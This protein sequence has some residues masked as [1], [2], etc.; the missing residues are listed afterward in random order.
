MGVEASAL[1][2]LL[3][4]ACLAH[5][6]ADPNK[7]EDPKVN[8]WEKTPK[9]K[10]EEWLEQALRHNPDIRVA[11][12]KV[13]EAEAELNRTRLSVAQKVAALYAAQ[14]AA[15]KSVESA[16]IAYQIAQEGYKAGRT[17]A[18]DLAQ[19]RGFLIVAKADLAKAEAELP[20][21][22]GKTPGSD[23]DKTQ[24]ALALAAFFAAARDGDRSSADKRAVEAGLRWLKAHQVPETST[25]EALRKALDRPVT[26]DYK[27]A[28]VRKILEELFENAGISVHMK[29]IPEGVVTLSVKETLPL[30]AALQLVQDSS[31]S[32]VRLV[33]RE[34]GVLVTD[35]KELPDGAVF[36]NDFW[37]SKPV[38]EKK[39]DGPGTTGNPPKEKI[40]GQVISVDEKSG[41]VKLNRGSDAGLERGH[42][43]EVYRLSPAAVKYLGRVRILETTP[44]EAVAQPVGKLSA[45]LEKGDLFANRLGGD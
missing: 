9:S 36:L 26:L 15:R 35:A 5:G 17:T 32:P 29:V 14:E 22:L 28:S 40:E 42:T 21:L 45:P 30:G 7:P 23:E 25:T 4:T 18:A 31:S 41:L 16:E 27:K 11:E 20:Y 6:Q 13:R 8:R 43:L 12:A 44:K 19:A 33:V 10:L 2:A 1:A 24:T 38:D 37:K 39:G 3:L 34:Y